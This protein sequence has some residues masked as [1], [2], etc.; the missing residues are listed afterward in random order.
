MTATPT[1]KSL[2]DELLGL[3]IQIG[4]TTEEAANADLVAQA[5][6]L[7]KQILEMVGKS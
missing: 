3:G 7:K 1:L 5:E 4:L 6:A 2:L